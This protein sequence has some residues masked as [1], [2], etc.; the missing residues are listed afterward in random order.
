[1]TDDVTPE[2]TLNTH[3]VAMPFKPNGRQASA[4]AFRA[5]LLSPSE[6]GEEGTSKR[7]ERLY[8][9]NGGQHVAIV[10]LMKASGNSSAIFSFMA[11]QLE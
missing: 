6:L 4:T 10:F 3:D 5:M 8:N 7:I 1:M 11:L 9:L 2:A